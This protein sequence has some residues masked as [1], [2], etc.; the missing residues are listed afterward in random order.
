MPLDGVRM[1]EIRKGLID[2]NQQFEI[3]YT[4]RDFIYNRAFIN[5]GNAPRN[6]IRE[7]WIGNWCHADS[8]WM[9]LK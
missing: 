5:E 8:Y 7:G 3:A 2:I 1:I 6:L 9:V 4:F